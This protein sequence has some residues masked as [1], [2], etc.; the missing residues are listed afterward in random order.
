MIPAFGFNK[1]ALRIV[2]PSPSKYARSELRITKKN[3]SKSSIRNNLLFLTKTKCMRKLPFHSGRQWRLP[4]RENALS[5]A[6][7]L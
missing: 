5:K 2:S 6:Y 4:N 7:I 3:I 1:A